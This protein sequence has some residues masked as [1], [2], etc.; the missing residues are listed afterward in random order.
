MNS[1]VRPYET[2]LKANQ[3]NKFPYKWTISAH[4]YASSAI[5]HSRVAADLPERKT[6]AEN[7]MIVKNE[8]YLWYKNQKTYK[9]LFRLKSENKNVIDHLLIFNPMESYT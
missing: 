6:N 4:T 1:I 2:I 8:L 9:F 3:M 7:L 5:D